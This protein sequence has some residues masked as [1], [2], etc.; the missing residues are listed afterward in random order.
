MN[1][2]NF[3][4]M[5][6]RWLVGPLF[7]PFAEVLLDHACL[8]SGDRVLDIA[9]GTGIM[10]RLAKQRMGDSGRVVGVDVSPHMLAVARAVA[11]LVEWR[12]GNAAA[13]PLTEPD[14]FDVVFCHQGLQFFPEKTVALREMKRALDRE[15]RLVIGVWPPLEETPFFRE[16]H[17]VAERLIGPIVDRRHSFGDEA[18]LEQ[19]IADA[20]FEKVRVE[21]VTRTIRVGDAAMF[22]RLNTMALVGMS[23]SS[24]TMTEDE[25]NRS[26]D[27][28]VSESV[29]VVRRYS[30]TGGLAFDLG[31]NLATAHT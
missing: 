30:A 24:S 7:R 21:R 28:I 3:P 10:A 13:L 1:T 8:R 16:T 17:G 15:G 2:S 22:V 5:Y 27:A 6:E 12:E 31:A 18:E 26:V 25:R 11:P 14:R 9:C 19:V 20:G 29:G 23:A 4:E